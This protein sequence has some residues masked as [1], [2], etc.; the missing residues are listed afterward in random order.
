MAQ[1][2]RHKRMKANRQ[3]NAQLVDMFHDLPGQTDDSEYGLGRC[4][5]TPEGEAN[6]N[7]AL[8]EFRLAQRDR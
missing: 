7:R 3:R 4:M 1:S 6:V 5:M 2:R 8:E